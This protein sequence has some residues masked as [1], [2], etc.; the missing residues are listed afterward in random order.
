MAISVPLAFVLCRV[1][2]PATAG[3]STAA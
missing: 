3:R 2:L 1:A